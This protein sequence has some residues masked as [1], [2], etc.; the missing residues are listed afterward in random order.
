MMKLKFWWLLWLVLL[1]A[2]PTQAQD[3]VTNTPVSAEIEATALPAVLDAPVVLSVE[4]P[5]PAAPAV[6]VVPDSG[7]RMAVGEFLATIVA[8][9]L[10][11]STISI[12][13]MLGMVRF[14]KN[15]TALQTA[16][17]GLIMSQP[18][19][20]Q[21]RFRDWVAGLKDVVEVAEKVTDGQPNEPPPA[22]LPEPVV[23]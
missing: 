23:G 9:A 19:T 18:P 15:D 5:T 8:T 22:P 10:A 7:V 2:V 12:G 13:A 1:L 11:A 20:T 17:E 4:T 14:I 3:F 16:I 6:V 21:A